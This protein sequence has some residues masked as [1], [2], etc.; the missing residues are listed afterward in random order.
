[1]RRLQVAQAGKINLNSALMTT[2]KALTF[3]ILRILSD[4]QFHS[5]TRL[6]QQF[7]VSA[8]SI[9]NAL[10]TVSEYGLK[11]NR[12]KGRG[13][14]LLQAP[15]WLIADK[16]NLYLPEPNVFDICVLPH[17]E[18]SNTL[19]LQRAANGVPSGS[20]LAVEWQ[21]AGRGR[22]GRRW[23]SELGNSLTFSLLWRFETGLVSLSGLSL[24]VGL[25][26]VRTLRK[27]GVSEVGLKWPN[28]LVSE[29]G[30]LAGVLI[31]AQGEARGACAV[32]IGIGLNFQSAENI[33]TQLNHGVSDLSQYLPQPIERNRLL[34]LL[35]QTL[36]E[37]LAEF[38]QTG[39]KSMRAEWEA[40]HYYQNRMIKM[41]LPDGQEM[42]GTVSG[43]TE[44]GALRVE[45]TRGE[46]IFHAGEISL[47]EV[48]CC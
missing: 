15:Q 11:L 23:H 39:F 37:I 9:H 47:R 6:A 12:V 1:M 16:I 44:E 13:Y 33:K 41:Q 14:Q 20:V 43:I 45:T 19:L 10:K 5:G 8:A 17:A 26:L 46:Q 40:E 18:S 36:A 7:Y 34:A 35:L 2:P 28:D 29:H 32:V 48:L 38:S 42:T 21:T 27:L 30:K 31:E 25:A 3:S 22:M 4:G 24:A